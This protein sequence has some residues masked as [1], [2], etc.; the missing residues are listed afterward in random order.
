MYRTFSD[1]KNTIEVDIN[2]SIRSITL[3]MGVPSS[4]RYR[5]IDVYSDSYSLTR[6]YRQDKTGYLF[7]IRDV[8]ELN[9]Q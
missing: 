4:S 5:L 3:S 7:T 1:H 6:T 8:K 2:E 9:D